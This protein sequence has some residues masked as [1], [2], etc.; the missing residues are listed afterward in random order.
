MRVLYYDCFSGISGDMHLGAMI[1]L[2]VDF[3]YLCNELDKLSIKNEF[4]LAMCKKEK[5]GISGTKIDVNLV[6]HHEEHHHGRTYKDIKSIVENSTL[7]KNIKDKAMKMFLNLAVAEGKIHNK[8]YEDIHFH[9][10]GAVDSIVDIVGAAICLDK[11][12]VEKIYCSSVLCGSGFVKCEHGIIPVPAPATLELLKHA[13][14]KLGVV[15]GEC[16]TPTGAVILASNVD[17]FVD[18]LNLD[19]EKI[20]YGVGTKEFCIPNVLRVFLGNT[21][22]L[23]SIESEILIET[24]IDDMSPEIVAFVEEQLFLD[25]AS[26]VYKTSITTKKNRLGIKL[27]VL[28]K[29]EF[30]TKI[31]NTIF[32]QT[33]SIGVR[34]HIVEKIALKRD[35]LLLKTSFGEISI[36]CSYLD[37]KLNNYKAEY[38]DCKKLAIKN[39][40]D[41][42]TIYFEVDKEMNCKKSM[43]S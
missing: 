2:G 29:K 23:C 16:T 25:G 30:E 24:N 1:E 31:I 4:S 19:V 43:K 3:S 9:E 40:V 14:I 42:E 6:N 17:E 12:S 35:F 37:G 18:E 5:K 21:K 32:K 13:N 28:V 7:S 10:V 38:E 36:K 26:D 33:S 34:K 27:S 41:I 8:N 11:L 15:D 39:N 22:E 20:G